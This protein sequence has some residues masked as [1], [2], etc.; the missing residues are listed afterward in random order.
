MTE[1]I[2]RWRMRLFA[3]ALT[4]A[5]QVPLSVDAQAQDGSA[6]DL[7]KALVSGSIRTIERGD[8]AGAQALGAYLELPGPWR[9]Q[10]RNVLEHSNALRDVRARASMGGADAATWVALSERLADLSGLKQFATAAQTSADSLAATRS[11]NVALPAAVDAVQWL[12]VASA[13][14]RAFQLAFTDCH[15]AVDAFAVVA[16]KP[17]R[18]LSAVSYAVGSTVVEAD[19]AVAVRLDSADCAV[20]PSQVGLQAADDEQPLPDDGRLG[21]GRYAAH[22]DAD[23]ALEL[24]VPTRAGFVYDVMVAAV[25]AA[26][27]PGVMLFRSGA[28]ASD[29]ADDAFARDDDGG[30]GLGARVA[31]VLGDGS[32]LRARITAVDGQGGAVSIQ[33]RESVPLRQRVGDTQSYRTLK[34]TPTVVQ[35]PLRLGYYRMSTSRL[36]A[37]VDTVVSVFAGRAGAIV[38]EN[39]DVSSNSFASQVCLNV[40]TAG[41]YLIRIGLVE[42]ASGSFDFVIEPAADC[43]DDG[44]MKNADPDPDDEGDLESRSDV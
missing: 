21:L 35:V 31:G 36:S 30:Y 17:G 1:R 38:A 40:T 34:G 43:P 32:V 3:A 18:A 4:C 7:L 41:D 14:R 26:A 20:A 10:V 33:I 15:P 16:G 44:G 8:L 13:G 22:L 9:A 39:D 24:S 37:E 11:G 12:R 28:T 42:P 2:N 29:A 6:S 5:M 27:D 23:R 25:D 19:G